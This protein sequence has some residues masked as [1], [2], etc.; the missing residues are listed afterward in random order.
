MV[1]Q[2]LPPSSIL[3]WTRRVLFL[4]ALGYRSSPRSGA[5]RPRA[6][7]LFVPALCAGRTVRDER[8]GA[9]PPRPA[10][11]LGP[12]SSVPP[13]SAYR[14]RRSDPHRRARGLQLDRSPSR[15]QSRSGPSLGIAHTASSGIGS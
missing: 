14:L 3:R 6:R 13:I 2:S 1:A 11:N 7:V 5:V 4:R 12:F 10:S 8:S 15:T 9:K